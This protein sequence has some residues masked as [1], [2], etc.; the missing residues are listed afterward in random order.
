[1]VGI[2]KWQ[3]FMDTM[4]YRGNAF[5]LVREKDGDYDIGLEVPGVEIPAITFSNVTIEE[6][7]VSGIT[8]TDLLKGKDIPFSATFTDDTANGWLKVP[9]LGKLKLKNGVKVA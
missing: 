9:F 4:F 1:M 3:F 6:N 7:T 2:G 8:R 5:L